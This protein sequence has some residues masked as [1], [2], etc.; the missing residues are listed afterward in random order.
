MRVSAYGFWLQVTIVVIGLSLAGR[1][2]SSRYHDPFDPSLSP[3]A[4]SVMGQASVGP[5]VRV[6]LAGST[7][8]S[9]KDL[10]DWSRLMAKWLNPA[11]SIDPVDP[12]HFQ[13]DLNRILAPSFRSIEYVY[14]NAP[15]SR[16]HVDYVLTLEISVTIGRHSF[17]KNRVHLQGVLSGPDV[18]QKE[19]MVG[20][21]NS[22]VGFPAT[23]QHFTEAR[24]KA[25]Y[26]FAQNLSASR[27]LAAYKN[28]TSA[29]TGL[30]K[31]WAKAPLS[32]PD[33]TDV[34]VRGGLYEVESKIPFN[35]LDNVYYDAASGELALI[36]HHDD[37]FKGA[38]I[39]YLQHLATLLEC[40]KA[41]VLPGVDARFESPG[42]CLARARA[43][44]A[45]KRRARGQA[46][47]HG[48]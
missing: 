11:S 48:G 18:G 17:G 24:Q 32:S 47:E 5:S 34:A 42:R 15:E 21:G 4:Q 20:D 33:G 3:T 2:D 8:A 23:N 28:S 45:G 35:V 38:G 1:A 27:L 22:K 40:P 30:Q 39:P 25:F 36:G 9:M 44:P 46:G 19:T 37:R 12:Q 13:D 26:E 10:A 41:G 6:V 43:D 29:P 14:W 16:S 7:G 31:A